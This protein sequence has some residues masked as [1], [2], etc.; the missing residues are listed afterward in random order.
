MSTRILVGDV[1]AMLATLPDE[2]VHTVVTSP[3][4][5]GLRDYGVVG[6]IGLEA[7]PLAFVSTMVE[8]FREVRRVL[9][10][11]GTCW[12]NLG[13]SYAGSGRGGNTGHGTSTT[14]GGQPD[15]SRVARSAQEV[16]AA[17]RTGS[18]LPAGLHAGAV[19]AGA[20]GRAWVPPPNGFKQ[21]DLVG[22]PW[23]VAFALQADGWY[24]RQDIIWAKPNP[25][26]ESVRDRCTKAHEYLF[27]FAKGQW[28]TKTIQFLDL[29]K[30]HIHLGQYIG[31]DRPD[32]GASEFCISFAT[33]IFDGA[34]RQHQFTLPPFYSEKWKQVPGCVSGDF[35]SS[36]PAKEWAAAQAARFLCGDSTAKEFLGEINRFGCDVADTRHLLI[37]GTSTE[38]LLP[39]DIHSDGKGSVAVHYAG[40]VGKID[41][42]HQTIVVSVPTACNY[43][44]DQEAIRTPFAEET[45]ALSFDTMEFGLRDKYRAAGNVNPPKGQL[46]YEQG[47]EKQRTKAGLLAF[48]QKT[49]A[50]YKKPDGWDTG[51]GGHGTIHREGREQGEKAPDSYVPPNGANKRSVWTVATQPF[52]EAH[53]ATFPPALIEPCILAGCPVGGT[54]LDPFGGAG[55]TGLV[56]DRHGRDAILIEL[57]PDYAEM[58]RRRIAGESPLFAE[59]S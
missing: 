45:K 7:S 51:P 38:I 52:K 20:T 39:P 24:L 5:W 44:F 19:D 6:Q 46:A 32:F 59:V 30:E 8:V 47:D 40:K 50:Q 34:Q 17:Q 14:A 33:A 56:A 55:T 48:A 3:P 31:A 13:D 4:Y 53:F 15:H 58:A 29:P 41:F 18:R 10:A 35:T 49:R 9:R 36:L 1:R 28:R 11:D 2:S 42:S 21:K 57:N 54:V 23:R 12:V 16:S 27:L 25:M 26:P 43:Y 22:I 37:G